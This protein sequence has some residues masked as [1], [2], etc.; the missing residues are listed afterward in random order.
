MSYLALAKRVL[1]EGCEDRTPADGGTPAADAARNLS[2]ADCACL[3]LDA[4]P[5]IED[6]YVIG[7]LP[8]AVAH[9]PALLDAL[10]DAENAIDDLAGT[11]P[12]E[13]DFRAVLA[14]LVCAWA[15]ISARFGAWQER[16]A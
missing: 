3:L 15:E 14:V 16:H 10:H 9:A 4:Q 8:W 12:E 6:G 1:A 2:A 7:A 5:G 13:H 11:S